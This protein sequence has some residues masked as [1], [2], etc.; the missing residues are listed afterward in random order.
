MLRCITPKAAGA[1]RAP[2]RTALV[3]AGT[4]ALL[5]LAGWAAAMPVSAQIAPPGSP[6]EGWDLSDPPAPPAAPDGNVTTVP[7]SA[8]QPATA[9]GETPVQFLA[10]LTEDGQRIEQGLVWRI[11][12]P[13]ELSDRRGKLIR[14]ERAPSP[15]LGLK[16]G[17][18]I[19]NA[20]FGRANLTRKIQVDESATAEPKVEKFVLN[21]GGLRITA[22]VASKPAP[23]GSV[24]Y[25]ILTD[26]DQADE[27][28]LVLQGVKPGLVIR[29]NAG[30][31]HIV[32]TYGDAN[33][34]VRT[35]VTVEAGKLTEAQIQ[36]TFAKV[37]FKLVERAGGEALPDTQW[38]IQTP[39]GA[40]VK[41]SV[42]ALPAHTLAP[43]TYT[44]V[45]RNKA[46]A[47]RRDFTVQAGQTAEVEI[48]LQ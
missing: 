16:P 28:R 12:E 8:G 27:R 35:D 45:A 46:R 15:L 33:A 14:T 19:V 5:W 37:S 23:P 20:A 41:E 7:R 10:L 29:L 18:Y 6:L 42:G 24:T 36:H 39:E 21:A 38:T 3:K 4:L 25:A 22:M 31:Y 40:V 2:R 17:N 30:I 43:G 13:T 32:S 26:R 44:V 1:Q 34:V 47:F 48:V 11:Y 9:A